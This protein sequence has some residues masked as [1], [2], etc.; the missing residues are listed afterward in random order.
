MDPI[1]LD[2]NAGA[3]LRPEALRA[4]GDAAERCF[5]NASS[6]HAFG[7]SARAALSRARKQVAA[8]AG[9]APETLVFTGGATESNNTVLRQVEGGAHVVCA[10]TEHPSVLEELAAAGARGVRV[11]RLPVARDGRLDPER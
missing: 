1:Y 9:V 7:A 11:T 2:H 5:G 6:A 3:P 4:L 8:L 10:A